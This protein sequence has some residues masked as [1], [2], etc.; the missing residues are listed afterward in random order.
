MNANIKMILSMGHGSFGW[1]RIENCPRSIRE[2]LLIN[3]GYLLGAG[4]ICRSTVEGV[5]KLWDLTGGYKPSNGFVEP[6]T[7]FNFF[8]EHNGQRSS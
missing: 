6:S 1:T 5:E 8:G 4:R 7:D 3:R 2:R